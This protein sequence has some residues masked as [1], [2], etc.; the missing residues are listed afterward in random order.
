MAAGRFEL[1]IGDVS[2]NELFAPYVDFTHYIYSMN[3]VIIGPQPKPVLPF[4]NI[5]SPFSFQTW[6]VV[7]ITI[8]SVGILTLAIMLDAVRATGVKDY[9]MVEFTSEAMLE[10]IGTLLNQ[11]GISYL[12]FVE[13]GKNMLECLC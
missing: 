11:G 4:L 6:I 8:I 7:L 1:G 2:I 13:H 9:S 3:L 5:I 10:T 12:L